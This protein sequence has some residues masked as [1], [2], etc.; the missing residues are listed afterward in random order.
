MSLKKLNLKQ[1]GELLS[2]VEVCKRNFPEWRE[3]QCLFNTLYD[4][5]PDLAE[6]LRGTNNDPF[7]DRNIKAC[8]NFIWN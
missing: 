1:L 4:Y 5:Y 3:G 8:I 2:E 6:S 7:Y